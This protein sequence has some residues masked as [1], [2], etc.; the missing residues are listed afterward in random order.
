MS[1]ISSQNNN[2]VNARAVGSKDKQGVQFGGVYYPAHS[3][4][5]KPVSARWEGN[6]ALNNRSYTDSQ[7]QVQ[8]GKRT[9]MRMVVW[10]SK[11][12]ASGKGLADVFAKCISVGKELSC[13]YKIESFDKR[14]FVDG[15]PLLDKAGNAITYPA[16]NFRVDD[17]VIFGDDSERVVSAEINAFQGQVNF[18]SRPQFWNVAGHADNVAWKQI[19]TARMA[20]VWDGGGVYG[21]ARTIVPEGA[22]IGAGAQVFA[23][24]QPGQQIV[25]GTKP[26]E[27]GAVLTPPLP[28]ANGTKPATVYSNAAQTMGSSVPI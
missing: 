7:G 21:Y 9:F 25:A 10:N 24:P 13:N 23:Q 12:A 15:Q 8:E 28:D 22:E 17:N 6:F 16:I 19:V 20:S 2:I 14:L 5:G 27:A 4:N 18:F 11:N 3:K 1:N 26:T